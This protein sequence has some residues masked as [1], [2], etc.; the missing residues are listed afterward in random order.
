MKYFFIIILFLRGMENG[1]FF[2]YNLKNM[3]WMQDLF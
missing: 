2:N 3:Y 1:S